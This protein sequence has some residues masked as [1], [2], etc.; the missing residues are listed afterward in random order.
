MRVWK[1]LAYADDKTEV[2]GEI[3]FAVPVRSANNV[4]HSDRVV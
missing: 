4:D 3:P 2:L 1:W